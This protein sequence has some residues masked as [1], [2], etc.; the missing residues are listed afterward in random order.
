MPCTH[1]LSLFIPNQVL[2]LQEEKGILLGKFLD[3]L[4]GESRGATI[5]P[6]KSP[7][8]DNGYRKSKIT[9]NG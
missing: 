9:A 5:A 3:F 4:H 1:H 7:K 8:L 6:G 2:E